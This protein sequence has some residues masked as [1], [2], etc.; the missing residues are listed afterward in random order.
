VSLSGFVMVKLHQIIFH[1]VEYHSFLLC[2][3]NLA[4]WDGG[5]GDDSLNGLAREWV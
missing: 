2:N 4:I 5:F 1:T 3:L